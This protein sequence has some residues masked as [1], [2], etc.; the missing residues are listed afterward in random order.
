MISG[1]LELLRENHLSA[2]N[3]IIFGSMYLIMD[4][5]H[6]PHENPIFFERVTEVTRKVFSWVGF[7]GSIVLLIFLA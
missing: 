1:L 7:A 2:L 6:P 5:Y 4:N 3:W